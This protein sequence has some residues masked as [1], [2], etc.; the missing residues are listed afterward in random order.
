MTPISVNSN[1]DDNKANSNQKIKFLY[2]YGGKILPRPTDGK[3]LYSGGLTRVLSVDRS[4]T[5]P[6]SFSSSLSFY[7][8]NNIQFWIIVTELMV[9]FLELC[10][11]SMTLKCKLPTE[12]LDVLV[13]I[14]CDEELVNLIEEYSR[15]FLSTNKDLKITA[16]L[17]PLKSLQ[18]I[19]SPVKKNL[20][21]SCLRPPRRLGIWRCSPP[22]IT[23]ASP[24]LIT[25]GGNGIHLLKLHRGGTL[26][27]YLLAL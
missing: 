20:A 11:S 23:T 7:Y 14:T 13:T 1:D 21:E 15:F 19:S 2:S 16:V 26:Y 4:I 27:N 10:G 8:Y 9:R 12:D 3:L 5:F 6:G 24:H 17:F 22:V 25:L 18:I